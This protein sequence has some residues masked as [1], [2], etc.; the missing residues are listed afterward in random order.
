M[1]TWTVHLKPDAEPVLVREG[2]S[3]GAFLFGPLWLLSQRAWVPGV[4]VLALTLA[5]SALAPAPT[6]A[7]LALGLG[8]LLGLL[9]R[10]LVRWSLE[11]RGYQLAHV[12]AARDEGGALG[13]LLAVRTDLAA[14]YLD[15]AA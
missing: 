5:F 6:R 2:W 1:K 3:W 11:R 8:A 7:V 13:R 9:G 12:L 15:R 4:V 14:R 10:D